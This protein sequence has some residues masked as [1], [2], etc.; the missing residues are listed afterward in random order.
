MYTFKPRIP[1]RRL[2]LEQ[3]A[4]HREGIA[5]P[6]VVQPTFDELGV[7]LFEVTFV[8]FDLETTGG[9]PG[10]HSITEIGA[11]KVRGGEVIG[12][13]ATLVN[14]EAPIPPSIT[15]LTGITNAMVLPAPKINEVLP[16]FVEF[17]GHEPNTVL[18]AH[19]ARFD[20]G[21]IRGAAA[22]LEL[23]F[24]T[25]QVA[26]TV[27]LARR[28][29]TKEEVRNY[30][31]STLAA[32]VGAEVT[33]S[34]RALD[35]AR[36]TVD[37]L[38]AILSRLGSL[39]VTHLEDLATVQNKVSAHRRTKA[40][41]A[42]GLP[43]TPGIYS[44]IGP[45][46]EI[47][48]VGTS[49]NI[50]KRVRA[51]FTAAENRRRIGE[52]VDLAVRVDAQSTATKLEANIL[53]VRTIA[54]LKPPFNRRSKSATQYWLHLTA[55]PHPRL[56]I[57]RTIPSTQLGTVLGP[58]TSRRTATMSAELLNDASNLRTC[59]QVLPA[60]PDGRPA[61]HLLELGKCS[62]PCITGDGQAKAIQIVAD[63]LTG[64]VDGVHDYSMSRMRALAEYGKFEI[65]AAERTRLYALV[66]G[67]KVSLRL[68]A[69]LRAGRIVAASR[70]SQGW[71][72]ISIDHG[73][74][75]ESRQA[76]DA[77]EALALAKQLSQAEPAPA[78]LKALDDVSTDELRLID[79]WLWRANVRLIHVDHPEVL[80]FGINSAMRIA[81]PDIPG[82]LGTAE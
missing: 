16:S 14:P 34:H 13:F 30:K 8:V 48:Y 29:I 15:V 42:D 2:D 70:E 37:V 67:A 22:A 77:H 38:H 18:V 46:D 73:R 68:Q 47:L 61:C 72:I 45:G 23:D 5:D 52:M 66:G 4:V 20:V 27:L 44:F 41:L 54:E 3:A 19:N 32:F 36:A 26:D 6:D 7:P 79:E 63:A 21:H 64:N 82:T 78:P 1:G 39:G 25:L 43:R 76:S 51:Y 11:V 65:A 81:L 74:L 28:V 50:Y 75:R 33:P 17:I 80:A 57:S 35:D 24:P 71:E 53:E 49:N 60:D 59:V 69:L 55:E 58:F 31:L 9:P 62:A 10:A 40:K 12:E 56:K